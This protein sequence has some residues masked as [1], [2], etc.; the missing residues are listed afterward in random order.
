MKDLYLNEK[1][2]KEIILSYSFIKEIFYL[3]IVGVDW[4]IA[5]THDEAFRLA[6]FITE[7]LQSN[8]KGRYK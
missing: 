4:P 6:D 2:E 1:N 3:K 5:I 7:H 8:L